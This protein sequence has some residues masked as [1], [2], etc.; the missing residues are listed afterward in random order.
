MP[1][2]QQAWSF[3]GGICKWPSDK[4]RHIQQVIRMKLMISSLELFS[5]IQ[6]EQPW[7]VTLRLN[8]SAIDFHIDTGVEVTVIKTSAHGKIEMAAPHY[9]QLRRRLQAQLTKVY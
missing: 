7:A 8:S 6:S 3:S 2:V 4:P 5:G 9:C 1:Q